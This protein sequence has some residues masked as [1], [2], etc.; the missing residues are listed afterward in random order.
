MVI[1][2]RLLTPTDIEQMMARDEFDPDAIFELVDGEI[3]WLSPAGHIHASIC[4]AIAAALWPFAKRIGAQLYSESAGFMVGANRQQLRS[5]DVSL[6]TKGRLQIF[7][8]DRPFGTEAPDLAVEVL[9]P[10]QHGEAYAR[11]KVAEYL[12]AGAMLVWLVDPD[13]QTIRVYQPNRDEYAVYTAGSEIT[14]D[15]I[16]PG[17]SVPV[18]ELF[19]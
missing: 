10:E 4:V 15:A 12:A 9:S 3:L 19:P 18:R 14:L 11:P 13:N 1:M 7:L 8:P 6:V 5:P 16:A 17:F 2:K